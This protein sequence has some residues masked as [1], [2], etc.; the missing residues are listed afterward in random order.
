MLY[1]NFRQ[2]NDRRTDQDRQDRPKQSGHQLT[3]V[4]GVAIPEKS[5]LEFKAIFQEEWQRAHDTR[6]RKSNVLLTL[7]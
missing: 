7:L 1:E 5:I 4:S 3:V 6:Q 2:V